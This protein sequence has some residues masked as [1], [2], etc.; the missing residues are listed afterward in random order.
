MIGRQSL[1]YTIV[2]EGFVIDDRIM[3]VHGVDTVISCYPQ[4]TDLVHRQSVDAAFCG[5]LIQEYILLSFVV[6]PGFKQESLFPCAYPRAPELIGQTV[7]MCV[8]K[9]GSTSLREDTRLWLEYESLL[10][11]SADSNRPVFVL[12]KPFHVIGHPSRLF[13]VWINVLRSWQ[14][15][16]AQTDDTC[17]FLTDPDVS[18]MICH[19]I[20]QVIGSDDRMS[21]VCRIMVEMPI[22]RVKDEQAIAESRNVGIPVSSLCNGKPTSLH[23]SVSSILKQSKRHG[24]PLSG[25]QV[26]DTIFVG[27]PVVSVV[28]IQGDAVVHLHVMRFLKGIVLAVHGDYLRS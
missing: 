5:A 17:L 1:L 18:L 16:L 8:V 23:D 28:V 11:S 20:N 25:K 7:N 3:C 6:I 10:T 24:F 2:S 4:P 26:Q 21:V 9:R 14:A 12:N 15:F 27:Y 22:G 13:R 19:D